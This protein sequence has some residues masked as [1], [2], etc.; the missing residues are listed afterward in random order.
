MIKEIKAV[1]L[2]DWLWFCVYLRRNEF[3]PKLGIRRYFYRYY[4]GYGYDDYTWLKK[5]SSDRNRAHEILNKLD[6]LKWK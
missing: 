4:R 2:W 1:G 3:S 6:D 5:L